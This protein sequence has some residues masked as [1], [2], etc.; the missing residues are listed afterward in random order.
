M[1]LALLL[2]LLIGASALAG[3][4][5]PAGDMALRHDIQRLADAGIIK[6]PTTTWPLAWGPI[7]EDLGAADATQL[8]AGVAAALA[9]NAGV[10]PREVAAHAI[11]RELLKQGAYLSPSIVS[12]QDAAE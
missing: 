4:Y 1:R 2:S 3:P 7:L 10:T 11:Q 5:I 6:G 9:A 8:P 12:A